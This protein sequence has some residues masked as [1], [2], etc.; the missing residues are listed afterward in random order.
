MMVVFTVVFK[1]S[2]HEYMKKVFFVCFSF[3]AT[4][5]VL[6]LLMALHLVIIPRGLGETK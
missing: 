5:D 6:G 3:W 2:F 1:L 4:P